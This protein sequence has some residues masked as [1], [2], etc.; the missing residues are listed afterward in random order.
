MPPK[1]QK[2]LSGNRGQAPPAQLRLISSVDA[3]EEG[4]ADQVYARDL[5]KNLERYAA[6]VAAVLKSHTDDQFSELEREKKMLE[7]HGTQAVENHRK[8]AEKSWTGYD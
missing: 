4:P 5:G 1:F 8:L 6:R 7:D 2:E 3:D